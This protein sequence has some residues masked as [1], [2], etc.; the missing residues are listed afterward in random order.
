MVVQKHPVW[1]NVGESSRTID[2]G[3]GSM[4]ARQTL[5]RS[6]PQRLLIWDYLRIA[7]HELTNPYRAKLLLSRNKLLGRGDG[8]AAII[9]AAPY[10]GEPDAAANTL[11]EFLRD[12]AP[13]IDA[14]LARV[15][16]SAEAS[17]R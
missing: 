3:K 8:G 11:T 1:S 16:Y 5:L 9:V 14:A 12:M 15:E 13:S 17:A 7:G 6:A 10:D 4:D 2:L